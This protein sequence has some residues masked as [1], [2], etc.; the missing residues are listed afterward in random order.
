[1]AKAHLFDTC[2][3]CR[4]RCSACSNTQASEVVWRLATNGGALQAAKNPVVARYVVWK[5]NVGRRLG[6]G[7][8]QPCHRAGGGHDDVGR[9]AG[10]IEGVGSRDGGQRRAAEV[11]SALR[12]PI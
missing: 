5:V 12:R 6:I 10:A 1:M 11:R 2:H 9:I 7:L 8:G 3:R 4:I